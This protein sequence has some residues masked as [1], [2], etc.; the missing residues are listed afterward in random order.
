MRVKF[1]LVPYDSGKYEMGMGKGPGKILSN[2]LEN[3]LIRAGHEV[4]TQKIIH[5]HQESQ[6]DIQSAFRI[7]S[8]LSRTVAETIGAD[9]F[10]IILAG[11]CISSVGILSGIHDMQTSVIW[12]DA[13]GDY[14]TPETTTSGYLDGM[15]LSIACGKCWR[16]LSS[17][18][19]LYQVVPEDQVVLL[20]VRDIDPEEVKALKQSR[21]RLVPPDS[22]RSKNYTLPEMKRDSLKK[23]HIHF[24]ADVIDESIGKANQFAV[25]N[26]LLPYEIKNIFRWSAANFNIQALAVTAYSP[27]YDG[28][29]SICEVIRESIVTLL[30]SMPSSQ[31]LAV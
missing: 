9:I 30:E 23:L 26:G 31:K 19:P 25:P 4:I 7:N 16:N 1:I 18:D 15:A 5:E 21:I 2:G 12:L 24:D 3:Q 14:N 17:I 10:P 8:M 11:N 29:G 6:T 13:H 27:D 28:A 20:G 22:F